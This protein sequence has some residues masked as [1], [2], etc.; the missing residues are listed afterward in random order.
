MLS[1]LEPGEQRRR[2]IQKAWSFLKISLAAVTL[3]PLRITLLVA[4][5]LLMCVVSAIAIVLGCC[6]GRSGGGILSVKPRNRGQRAVL[7]LLSPL[8]R[9]CLFVMGFFY[10]RER[11][12]ENDGQTPRAPRRCCTCRPYGYPSRCWQC[13][14][15]RQ[16]AAT[17]AAAAAVASAVASR[18]GSRGRPAVAMASPVRGRG[19]G[20]GRRP[21]EEADQHDEEWQR[22]RRMRIDAFDAAAGAT[23][24]AN[25]QTIADVFYIA[26][27]YPATSVASDFFQLIPCVFLIAK[28]AGVLFVSQNA[29]KNGGRKNVDIIKAYQ[30]SASTVHG[31]HLRRLL[32]FPEGTTSNGRQILKL[33]TG[34]FVAGL[35]VRPVLLRYRWRNTNPSFTGSFSGAVWRII[36][37]WFTV[38]EVLELPVYWPTPLEQQ[39]PRAYADAVQAVMAKALAVNKSELSSQELLR[40]F[41]A[42]T[43]RKNTKQPAAAQ[44]KNQ[45]APATDVPP[46]AAEA[47]ATITQ[48]NR[49]AGTG[50]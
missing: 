44:K 15:S 6:S 35:P 3:V 33:R 4:I 27:R 36:G 31:R 49:G 10:I 38:L 50:P 37:S 8:A 16:N 20:E 21:G 17:V 30:E 29:R 40:A 46:V 47:P 14:P 12:V 34:A 39:N 22:Q 32:I 45:V 19:E 2:G 9:A 1:V 23:L 48:G 7:S 13:R 28:A 42:K 24:V 5:F 25:H 41:T 18:S 26:W 43:D 11:R